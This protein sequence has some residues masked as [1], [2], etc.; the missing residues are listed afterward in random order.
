MPDRFDWDAIDK[1]LDESKRK[2]N[3]QLASQI[4]A[5]TRL[6]DEEVRKLFPT[7]ADAKKLAELMTIVQGST[8]KTEAINRLTNNIE[9]LGGTVLTLLGKFV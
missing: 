3:E 4:S 7:E 6:T 8:S 1:A 9:R 2:T 5:L